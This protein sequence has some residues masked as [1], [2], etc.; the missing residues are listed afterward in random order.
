MGQH[1]GSTGALG[2]SVC[3]PG[4][5]DTGEA[6]AGGADYVPNRD[7]ETVGKLDHIS[8]IGRTL[9]RHHE[10][11]RPRPIFD[12]DHPK[13]IHATEY[14][15]SSALKSV[16]AAKSAH[17]RRLWLACDSERVDR[18]NALEARALIERSRPATVSGAVLD[19][20]SVSATVGRVSFHLVAALA[21]AAPVVRD[22]SV[23]ATSCLVCALTSAPKR[24]A[25]LVSQSQ[26]SITTTA[27]SVP[28]ALLYEP[29]R[30]A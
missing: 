16:T 22:A 24:R 29:N 23:S 7:L 13:R 20:A 10:L 4:Q 15:F 6:V 3:D 27:E 30:A 8:L 28:H 18:W 19:C 1:G 5:D 26:I 25:A 12:H 9:E 17:R 14:P 11:D 2:G 21:A